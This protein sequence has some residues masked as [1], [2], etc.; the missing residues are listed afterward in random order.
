MAVDGAGN[1][2]V[3]VQDTTGTVLGTTGVGTIG[4]GPFYLVLGQYE[5]LP[6]SV[7]PS[8][9]IWQ[10]VVV[11]A[12]VTG[13]QLAWSDEFNDAAGTLPNPQNYSRLKTASA[14]NR[15]GNGATSAIRELCRAIQN[16]RSGC[17]PWSVA[18]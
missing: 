2:T 7:G 1:T 15:S 3:T 5:G 18:H 9:C 4:T 8:T 6:T 10:Q 17:R 11:S 12:G 14:Q 16:T 13:W